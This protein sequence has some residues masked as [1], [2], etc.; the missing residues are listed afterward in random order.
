MRGMK[1]DIP[2]KRPSTR[3]LRSLFDHANRHMP[4]KQPVAG[5]RV[6]VADRNQ[7]FPES[8]VR[9]VVERIEIISNAH[10]QRPLGLFGFEPRSAAPAVAHA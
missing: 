6:L 9:G 7:H 1:A 10:C 2:S 4:I 8:G 5:L 3:P